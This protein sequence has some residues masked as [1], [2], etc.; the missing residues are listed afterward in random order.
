MIK[1]YPITFKSCDYISR[2]E[3]KLTQSSVTNYLIIN[4]QY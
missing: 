3:M 1:Y 4:Y 2:V